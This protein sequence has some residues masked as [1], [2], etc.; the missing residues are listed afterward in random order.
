M[1]EGLFSLI[2]LS[3]SGTGV[4]G[5]QVDI[6]VS[7]VNL[8]PREYVFKITGAGTGIP[9]FEIPAQLVPAYGYTYFTI[10]VIMPNNDLVVNV[11]SWYLDPDHFELFQDVLDTDVL[12]KQGGGD[13]IPTLIFLDTSINSGDVAPYEF[14][15]FQPYATVTFTF[16][17]ASGVIEET[18]YQAA[19][20]SGGGFGGFIL[21]F[22]PGIYSCI[23]TDNYGHSSPIVTITIGGSSINSGVIE[24]F[25]VSK[26]SSQY[27]LSLGQIPAQ[28]TVGLADF[29]LTVKFRANS[30]NSGR[31]TFTCRAV[32][33]DPDG[34]Q[35]TPVPSSDPADL[36]P[37]ELGSAFGTFQFP[38]VNKSGLWSLYIVFTLGDGTVV[39]TWGPLPL[40]N[41]SGRTGDVTA[42]WINKESEGNGIA[43][44]TT[45]IANSETWEIGCTI[46]NTCTEPYDV[47]IEYHIT[48]PT[49]TVHSFIHSDQPLSPASYH[50]QPGESLPVTRN[51]KPTTPVPVNKTG[52]WLYTINLL[53]Y[54]VGEQLKTVS[55]KAFTATGVQGAITSMWYNK[56]SVDEAGFG[57]DVDA[58]GQSFEVG[59]KAKITSTDTVRAGVQVEIWDPTGIKRTVPPIDYTGMA[60]GV[61]YPVTQPIGTSNWRVDKT[62]DWTI[63]LKLL[64]EN[65]GT[66]IAEWPA[67]GNGLLFKAAPEAAFSDLTITGYRKKT[68]GASAASVDVTEGDILEVDIS[69]NYD[70]PE[71][72]IKQITV[73]LSIAPGF[74]YPLSFNVDL[75]EG[76]ELAA[77]TTVD[78]PIN[79]SAGLRNDTYDIRAELDDL[80]ATAAGAV[81]VTGMPESTLAGIGEMVLLMVMMMIMSMM[82]EAMG[83]LG[84]PAGYPKP[85]TRAVV[86]G[87]KAIGSGVKRVTRYFGER[88][89]EEKRVTEYLGEGEEEY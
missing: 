21:N 69:F 60:P 36:S 80:E 54:P 5:S 22:T 63:K 14:S 39:A 67:T 51:V 43:V 19:N 86:R 10:T 87:A 29:E 40:F 61:E 17:A 53:T 41:V 27:K 32:V 49:S 75:D 46:K 66:V 18:F 12:Y 57:T 20:S 58:D 34:Y 44:P 76:T 28:A 56:G 70:S 15:G 50:L 52:D 72:F 78:I 88:G 81:V 4:P 3:L 89:E 1:P 42:V 82:M 62:G 65:D 45:V 37:G 47:K 31:A 83:G 8:Q 6:S 13:P 48:D 79:A 59:F 16:R 71:A 9:D 2:E 35:L 24:D 11:I 25:I 55:G 26:G 74:D 85:V 64:K 30:A 84:E 38:V 7:L 33:T 23:A 77:E 73:G 68:T